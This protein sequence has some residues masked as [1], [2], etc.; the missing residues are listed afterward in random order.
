MT[1]TKRVLPQIDEP[2]TIQILVVEDERIVARDI[3]ACLENLGY[4]VP[5]IAS[6]GI[7]AVE[8]AKMLHPDV[9]LM[10]IRLN[11]EMDGIQAAQQI[12]QE[13]HIPVVYSTGHSD[14]ATVERAMATE[15]LGYVLKPIKEQDL[16]VTL[17][18]ALKRYQSEAK[19]TSTPLNSHPVSSTANTL[20]FPDG[21]LPL[22]SQFYI[23]HSH[24]EAQAY[25]EISKP[26][27]LVRI[28]APRKMG[29][30]SLLLRIRQQAVASGY[31]GIAINLQEA[32][33]TCFES[34]D[35]FLR[36]FCT[37]VACQL[38]LKPELDHIWDDSLG[39]K[40]SCTSYFENELFERSQR[41]IVLLLDEINCILK[42]PTIAQEFLSLL[43][44]WYE[45]AKYMP[46]WQ[47]LRLVIF[48]STEIHIP[49]SV[50]QSPFNVGLPL[51][52]PEFTQIQIQE[53][54]RRYHLNWDGEDAVTALMQMVGGHPYL[55]HLALYHL[56]QPT[57][58]LKQL[59]Q[60]AP[61]ASGIYHDHLQSY[62]FFLQE[63]PELIA[64]LRQLV[65]GEADSG[66]APP[67]LH[68]LDSMGLIK[69]QENRHQVSCELYRLY[70]KGQ[71]LGEESSNAFRIGQLEEEN[72]RLQGLVNIDA[73]TQIAN[74]RYFDSY[75]QTEWRRMLR[76]RI[77]LSLILCDIDHF[78]LYNDTWGH[79]S[80][81]E[82]LRQVAQAIQHTLKRP[83]DL[84]A[85]YGGEEFAIILPQT[86]ATGAIQ[87]AEDIRLA[88]KAILLPGNTTK[89]LGLPH[90]SVTV[91][92]GVAT[93]VPNPARSACDLIFAA[94]K[95]LYQSKQQGRDRTTLSSTL[96]FRC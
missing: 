94:D 28:K 38:K 87:I 5:A 63:Q 1:M 40:I 52:L 19:A 55:V 14:R 53:L 58:T 73:L 27:S 50:K 77:S 69:L 33:A 85:R 56:A 20:E 21:P 25:A 6:S 29:K 41:P 42:Y 2:D 30:S 17:K 16:Y 71:N 65:T 80:G 32:D 35:K 4:V 43:R 36:W 7:E 82:C 60:E 62:W 93:T 64:A 13:L 66:L 51:K 68:Q 59:L 91:S 54:A 8:K 46:A 22:N 12:W 39:S 83:S 90:P 88:V 49:L 96:N 79:P 61:T 24:I 48:H 26:G 84:V 11:G 89:C 74:R 67:L 70:F 86:N 44:I 18:T 47:K 57:F 78:K 45:K 37:R 72:Q 23:E 92:L 3:K 76:D 95:A 31:A 10:D 75:L 15:P 9:V 34:L 81:D